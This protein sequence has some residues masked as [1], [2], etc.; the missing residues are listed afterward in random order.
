MAS[1]RQVKVSERA[2]RMLRTMARTSTEYK[3]RGVTGVVD[4]LLFDE[5]TTDG[6]GRP[7]GKKKSEKI[8][9]KG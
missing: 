4:K 5:F 8:E 1:Q 7:K 6:S 3:G 2:Y 9:E